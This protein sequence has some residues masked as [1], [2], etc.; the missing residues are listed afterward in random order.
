MSNYYNP[1]LL[2]DIN[3]C[4]FAAMVFVTCLL[5]GMRR[6]KFLSF[7]NEF[8]AI[9]KCVYLFAAIGMVLV[10]LSPCSERN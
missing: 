2:A 6:L 1:K 10:F 4:A 8:L 9:A 3:P 5:L 7:L